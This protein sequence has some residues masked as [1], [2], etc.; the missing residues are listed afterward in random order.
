MTRGFPVLPGIPGAGHV[1]VNGYWHP[2]SEGSC[3]KGPCYVHEHH[4]IP[5]REGMDHGEQMFVQA[6][7]CGAFCRNGKVVSR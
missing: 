4:W 3:Q 2:G 5:K 7:S 6:C 1:A